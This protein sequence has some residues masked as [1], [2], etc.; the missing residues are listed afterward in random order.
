M[1]EGDASY[2]SGAIS[3]QFDEMKLV[4]LVAKPANA[5][6]HLAADDTA[7]LGSVRTVA[8][9]FY[10]AGGMGY[11]RLRHAAESLSRA[12][13]LGIQLFGRGVPDFVENVMA[14]LRV[15]V[16]YAHGARIVR[17]GHKSLRSM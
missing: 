13:L 12:V 10:R 4:V 1:V 3:R 16:R 6:M 2:D 11:N 7:A 17:I 8:N 14:A 5:L 9:N 15:A